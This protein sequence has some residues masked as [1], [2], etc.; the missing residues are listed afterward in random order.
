MRH[1]QKRAWADV[2]E[3][4]V[5]GRVKTDVEEMVFH[6]QTSHRDAPDGEHVRPLPKLGLINGIF[7]LGMGQCPVHVEIRTVLCMSQRILVAGGI[8]SGEVADFPWNVEA[9]SLRQDGK[10][11]HVFL[12][13]Q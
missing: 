4:V 5:F 8:D 6:A 9:E 10:S 1:I 7:R 2:V 13:E 3:L 11:G 12:F